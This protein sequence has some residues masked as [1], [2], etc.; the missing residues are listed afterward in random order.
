MASD[1]KAPPVSDEQ[2]LYA[3]ILE[4]GVYLGLLVLVVT[5]ALYVFGLIEPAVPLADLPR[6]W[7]LNVHDYLNAVNVEHLHH[8]HLI[9]GWSWITML[10]KSDYLNFSG[11]ALLSGVTVACYV[12]I[13]P[14]LIRKRDFVYAALAVLES[15]ILALA[16]SGLLGVG[17]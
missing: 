13:V 15:L 11:I 10:G 8:D 9:T 17:H 14:T 4:T 12:G 1:V 3:K 6:Y 5:F 7:V 16:A 2:L